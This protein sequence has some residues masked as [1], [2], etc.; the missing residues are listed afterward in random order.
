MTSDK[1]NTLREI[2]DS[3][4]EQQ[5]KAVLST[6]G[7]CLVIAG[8]GSGKTRVL[9]TKIAYLIIEKN[10]KPWNIIALTFTNKTAREMKGRIEKMVDCDVDS[11]LMGTFHSCFS[12]ILR[13]EAEK[14]GYF[15]NFS[16]YDTSDSRS[17]VSK[18]ITDFNLDPTVYVT[19][20]I[21]EKISL[22]KSKLV[23]PE[24][25]R[26]DF[27]NE[28]D[29]KLHIER[30]VDIYQEYEKRCLESNAMDF[31]DILMNM[32]KLLKNNKD[33]CKKYSERFKYIFIDEF[34]DTNVLQYAI[35][36]L[37]GGE[38]NNICVVGD[39]S[40]SIYSFRGA[41][42]SNILNFKKDFKECEVIKLEQN[43]R[44][45]KNIVGLANSVIEK[46]K[47]R[48]DKKVRTNNEE[49][50]KC[51]IIKATNGAEEARIVSLII[52]D[53]LKRG[54][55]ESDFVILY[56][57]NFQ[58]RA[59]ENELKN[60]KIAYKIFGGMSFYQY[61]EVR[62]VIAFLRVVFNQNDSE[63]IKRTINKP[64]RGI[65]ETT[66]SQVYEAVEREKISMWEVLKKS[67][68][69]F[70]ARV[71]DLLQKY[72]KVI[73]P[74]IDELEKKNAYEIAV[75]LCDRVG[76]LKQSKEEGTAEGKSRYD[77]I[78]E[79]LNSIKMFVDDENVKDKSLGAFLQNLSLDDSD[80]SK[81]K[82]ND[83]K[84]VS[85]MT[86]HSVK[87]LEFTCVFV[88]GLEEGMFPILRAGGQKEIEE[89]RR[90]FY[91]AVTRAKSVLFLSYS[92]SRYVCGKVKESKKSR[93]LDDLNK[94]YVDDEC[95]TINRVKGINNDGKADYANYTMF[96][97]SIVSRK[98]NEKKCVTSGEFR[99]GAMVYHSKYGSGSIISCSSNNIIRAKF[100]K[101]GE[102]DLVKDYSKLF[103]FDFVE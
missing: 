85:L 90:L 11:L 6:D 49:G 96:K 94:K 58:A 34:Q 59:F 97:Y 5:K 65:G 55:T 53:K 70:G 7:V 83:K 2:I 43:Y 31:D 33:V 27:L 32:Y 102:K 52:K 13:V 100:A 67:T 92:T 37:I 19:N 98:I 35:I 61:E 48:I 57:A 99:E 42:V 81:E 22:M 4:N 45:T 16:I 69:L 88:V 39:H 101:Y 25:Y 86:V 63:A 72:V 56:R 74:S 79:L 17:L 77:N 15:S 40:Q 103:V 12:K 95:V 38:N 44:S 46:N 64:R 75:G 91:V 30:F 1:K 8:P 76:F 47:D 18:I 78:V 93:L 62:D 50:E 3:L 89:E 9:T 68:E 71:G 54:Y 41:T 84:V 66:L 23:T 24:V 60:Q 51:H 26:N 73:Q 21:F 80:R 29:K 82:E 36:K 10:V 14:I 20:S 28:E 87:G